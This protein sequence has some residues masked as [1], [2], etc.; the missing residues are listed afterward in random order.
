MRDWKQDVADLV[1]AVIHQ[2][3]HG[4]WPQTEADWQEVAERFGCELYVEKVPTRNRGVLLD[5][6]IVVR[7]TPWPAHLS[8]Y[9]AHEIAEYLLASEWEAPYCYPPGDDYK[10]RH[11]VARRV[12]W[13]V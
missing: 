7:W 6:V 13:G 4:R 5:D 10:E 3:N 9:I 8:R 1:I 2:A 12:E 11:A